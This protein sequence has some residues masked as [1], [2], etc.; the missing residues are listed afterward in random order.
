[1]SQP[2]TAPHVRYDYD[3][4]RKLAPEAYAA[5]VALGQAVDHSGLDKALTELVKL[6]TSQING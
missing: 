2:V 5:L 3:A 1:M 4:F 6:R